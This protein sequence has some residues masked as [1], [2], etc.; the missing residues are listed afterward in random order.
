MTS[1]RVPRP[2]RR[3]TFLDSNI[4]QAGRLVSVHRS[5]VGSSI[6]ASPAHQMI[7]RSRRRSP[8]RSTSRTRPSPRPHRLD[9]F[10]SPDRRQSEHRLAGSGWVKHYATREC[11]RCCRHGHGPWPYW[12]QSRRIRREHHEPRDLHRNGLRRQR[13]PGHLRSHDN[14]YERPCRPGRRPLPTRE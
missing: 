7:P 3:S 12:R 2:R 1:A 6:P 4:V 14:W 11:N 9:E 8:F 10:D 5:A 13:H